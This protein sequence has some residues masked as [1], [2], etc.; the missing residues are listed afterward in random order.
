M[1]DITAII[2]AAGGA[3]ALAVVLFAFACIFPLKIRPLF[4]W[5]DFWVGA[6]WDKKAR[7]LYVLPLPIFGFTIEW[8]GWS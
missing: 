3:V 7:K 2:Q 8:R 4:A 6:Y 5:F 1:A